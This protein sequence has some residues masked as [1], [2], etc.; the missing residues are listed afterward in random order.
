MIGRLGVGSATWMDESKVLLARAELTRLGGN[1][2]GWS[3]QGDWVAKAEKACREAGPSEPS[4][5]LD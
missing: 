4:K 3:I 1:A 5:T 2:R